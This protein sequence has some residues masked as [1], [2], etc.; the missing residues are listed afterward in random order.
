MHLFPLGQHVYILKD[1]MYYIIHWFYNSGILT[2]LCLDI[3]L[4]KEWKIMF[5]RV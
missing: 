1:L 2:F 3:P 5:Y 4:A